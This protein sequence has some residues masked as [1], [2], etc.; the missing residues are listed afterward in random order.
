MGVKLWVVKGNSP[1]IRESASSKFAACITMLFSLGIDDILTWPST[2]ASPRCWI[3]SFILEN[4]IVEE[5]SH[6]WGLS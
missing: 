6:P 2:M 1:D 5:N 3:G 4:P